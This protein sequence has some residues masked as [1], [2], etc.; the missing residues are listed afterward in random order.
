MCTIKILNVSE[1]NHSLD[2]VIE[3]IEEL[4]VEHVDQLTHIIF[5]IIE[6]SE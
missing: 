6:K 4:S 2:T 5:D 1:E 3:G